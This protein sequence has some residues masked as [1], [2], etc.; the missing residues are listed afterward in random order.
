[1]VIGSFRVK[2]L[3]KV[4]GGYLVWYSDA[5]Y[6]NNL[7][8]KELKFSGGGDILVVIV[9]IKLNNVCVNMTLTNGGANIEKKL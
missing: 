2:K 1:M 5:H 6:I 7:K 4:N 9:L 8:D 3:L